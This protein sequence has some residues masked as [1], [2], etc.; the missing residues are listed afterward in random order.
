MQIASGPYLRGRLARRGSSLGPAVSTLP[1]GG[2]GSGAS[3]TGAERMIAISWTAEGRPGP[4]PVHVRAERQAEVERQ[5]DEALDRSVCRSPAGAAGY[6]AGAAE[7]RR[8]RATA[9]DNQGHR[10]QTSRSIQTIGSILSGGRCGV[11]C[12]VYLVIVL[13]C[14]TLIMSCWCTCVRA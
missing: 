1:S 13:H 7:D 12:I 14:P 4:G 2:D 3:R 8:A 5:A 11:H 6:R 9:K 10:G